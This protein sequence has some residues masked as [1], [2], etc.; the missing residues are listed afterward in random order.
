VIRVKCAAYEAQLST[1]KERSQEVE[2]ALRIR[3]KILEEDIKMLNTYRE[4]KVPCLQSM[5]RKDDP[6]I[7]S[8]IIENKRFYRGKGE[9]HVNINIYTRFYLLTSCGMCPCGRQ[10]WRPRSPS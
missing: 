7:I 2:N 8:Y 6:H 4:H 1:V 10:M 3:V 9:V 5:R